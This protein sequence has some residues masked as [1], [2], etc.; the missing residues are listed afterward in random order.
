MAIENSGLGVFYC[1]LEEVRQDQS[2]IFKAIWG[3][4]WSLQKNDS[5]MGVN[6]NLYSLG[7]QQLPMKNCYVHVVTF[8]KKEYQGYFTYK[9]WTEANVEIHVWSLNVYCVDFI[10]SIKIL[11]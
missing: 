1:L 10:R 6:E 8:K 9:A 2:R 5:E 7:V 4:T 3:I 11:C